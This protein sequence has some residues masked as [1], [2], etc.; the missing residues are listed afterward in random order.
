MQVPPPWISV[1]DVIGA[2]DGLLLD[3]YG[4]LLDKTGPLPGAVAFVDQLEA[5]GKPYLILTNS[6]SRLPD[7]LAAEMG[8]MGFLT[9]AERI[10]TSGALLGPFFREPG[11]QGAA[12]VVLGTE[13]SA[14]YVRRAGGQPV[15]WLG[16][17]DAEVVVVADQQGV[18]MDVMD[19]TLTLT[20]R[21]LDAGR[22]VSVVLCNPDLIYPVAPGRYGFT[23]G[24]L[25]AM[26]E[27]VMRERYPGLAEPIVR[28]GKPYP[29]IFEEAKRRLG[30]DKLVMVG[31]QLATDI[32]G[33]SR[34]GIDS[35][36]V[37]TGLSGN[38]EV[39]MNGPRPTWLLP[40][41]R[42]E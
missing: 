10:L 4:V 31:D 37:S 38:V 36:L 20:V 22:P 40:S 17:R 8:A 3:A 32:L 23:A 7:A 30:V 41:L 1:P 6:A 14:E 13:E 11:L 28:L 33:A 9:G 25:A 18:T 29:P 35:V 42:G 15:P 21:R 12:C 39:A 34:F 27:A 24:G 5:A 2:Y 26:L 19:W 16:E